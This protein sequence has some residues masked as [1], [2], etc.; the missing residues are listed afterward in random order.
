MS[1]I[2]DNI[3]SIRNSLKDIRTAVNSKGANIQEGDDLN[4]WDDKINAMPDVHVAS[5]AYVYNNAYY[6]LSMRVVD[7]FTMPTED[8]EGHAYPTELSPYGMSSAWGTLCPILLSIAKEVTIPSYYT[9]FL[10]NGSWLNNEF[11]RAMMVE[12]LIMEGDTNYMVHSNAYYVP[13]IGY[14]GINKRFKEATWSNLTRLCGFYC[15]VNSDEAQNYPK[16]TLNF[17]KVTLMQ[18]AASSAGFYGD[19]TNGRYREIDFN[20]PELESIVL[21]ANGMNMFSGSIGTINMPKLKSI[22]GNYTWFKS[23]T[24]NKSY[25]MLCPALETMTNTSFGSTG[26]GGIKLYIG[27]NLSNAVAAIGNA[28]IHI[29][30][31]DSTTKMTLDTLGVSYTQDYQP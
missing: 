4:T 30:A 1:T 11:G 20:F 6:P 27:P 21:I 17:P 2:N 25:T 23:S 29:P 31:G 3:N 22:T 8:D 16:L 19:T 5:G 26:N 9:P 15:Y 10:L 12:K 14:Q 28:E 24:T 7:K 18:A 13:G